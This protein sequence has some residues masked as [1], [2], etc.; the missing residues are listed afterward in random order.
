MIIKNLTL[1]LY[2]YPKIKKNY[3]LKK[4]KNKKIQTL[5]QEFQLFI[6]IQKNKLNM[7]KKLK[8]VEMYSKYLEHVSPWEVT[9]S[10]TIYLQ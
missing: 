8:S 2:N 4:L 3:G 7:M 10:V 1:K 5:N 9:L 6:I